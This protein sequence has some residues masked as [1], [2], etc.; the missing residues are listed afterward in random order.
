[1]SQVD[2]QFFIT[3]TLSQNFEILFTLCPIQSQV[4]VGSPLT[5]KETL[6]LQELDGAAEEG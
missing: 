6:S 2:G 5:K 1:M 3:Y 4:L